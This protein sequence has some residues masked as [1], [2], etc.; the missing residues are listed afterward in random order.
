[1]KV[2][3]LKCIMEKYIPQIK[4][5]L[6]SLLFLTPSCSLDEEYKPTSIGRPMDV[7][8]S[9]DGETIKDFKPTI[10]ETFE[11]PQPYF[12]FGNENYFNSINVFFKG[13]NGSMLRHKTIVILVHDKNKKFLNNEFG[14]DVNALKLKMKDRHT[15]IIQNLWA[16]PQHVIFIYARTQEELKDY[17]NSHKEEV[18]EMTLNSE[19][20]DLNERLLTSPAALSH[21]D[22][23][24][25][26]YGC[27][28]AIPN[29]YILKNGKH[30][31]GFF[32]FIEDN[33]YYTS[34]IAVYA[35]KYKDTSQFN[36]EHIIAMRDSM[37]KMHIKGQ[38]EGT[39]MGTVPKEK[40]FRER[41]TKTK[42]YNG[43]YT[44]ELWGMWT[45]EGDYKAG[46]YINYT[47]LHEPTNQIMHVEGFLHY[48]DT[49]K[50]KAPLLRIYQS[51]PWSFK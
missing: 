16:Q 19:T 17:L 1:M 51:L 22:K 15:V 8:V 46:H 38:T 37:G 10:S 11:I 28:V 20:K 23:I 3:L 6:I 36:T 34:T 30:K 18:R 44:K 12:I 7:I 49:E 45:I 41:F 48:P 27:G 14:I 43:H 33:E 26:K 32:E 42:R 47:F 25:E 35:E 2:V 24:K 31:N 5:L 13:L 21:Y 39:F 4:I 40:Y 50:K 29:S 9:S